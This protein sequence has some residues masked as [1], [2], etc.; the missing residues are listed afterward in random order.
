VADD[1]VLERTWAA[2]SA[3][4]IERTRVLS[5]GAFGALAVGF[6]PPPPVAVD[7]Q[8]PALI[9]YSSGTT[10]LPKGVMLT[11]RNLVAAALQLQA[12]DLARPDDV[13]VALS[14]FFHVVGLHGVLNLGIVSG[15]T[16]VVFPRFDLRTFLQAIRD[17]RVSSIFITPP[18]INE[19]IK[20]PLVAQYDLSSL[21]SILC[22]AAPLGD[23]AEARAD[24][25]LGC[26]VRQ[27]FGMTEATGPV[28]TNLAIDGEIRRGSVG[29]LV[30][31]T[32]CQIVDLADGQPLGPGATGEI[33]VRGPQIMRGY[34]NQ[35]EATAVALTAEGWLHTGDVGY[36][37]AEGYLYVVDR[38]KEIIKYKA[39]QVAPAELEAVLG[40]HPG[41]LDSAVVPS[42][43]ADAGEIPKAYV[44]LHAGAAVSEAALLAYVAE[45]VAPYKKIR[46]VEFVQ[47]I[48][49][50]PTGKILRRVLVEQE[51]ARFGQAP[52][53]NDV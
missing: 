28:S 14:P 22:A 8:T 46:E 7:S 12:G 27:G 26:E 5:L 43:D 41:V 45:R 31:N 19:L 9:L 32:E 30:P 21:R 33:L 38:V 42:P 29:L 35:P 49:K 50:S 48:P 2:A 44:V 25:R 10:G 3:C 15:A 47:S 13:L 24:E 34:L 23:E 52:K 1:A 20:N 36:A 37:D 18:V 39:Y 16:V 17:Y 40:T 51:R 11:H 6:D 4:G 53:A